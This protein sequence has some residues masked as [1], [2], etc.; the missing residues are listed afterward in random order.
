M[1]CLGGTARSG[2]S[3]W[4]AAAALTLAKPTSVEAADSA[5][6]YDGNV[7]SAPRQRERVLKGAAGRR[8]AAEGCSSCSQVNSDV[9]MP[10]ILVEGSCVEASWT[11][12][13]RQVTNFAASSDSAWVVLDSAPIRVVG[14]FVALVRPGRVIEQ[15]VDY[16]ARSH[17]A[18]QTASSIVVASDPGDTTVLGAASLEIVGS[19]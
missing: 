11:W 10:Q 18:P 12:V 19:R 4:A 9:A 6:V 2:K 13:V 8:V 1:S 3:V 7:V 14:A 16:S 15:V 5:R 17:S